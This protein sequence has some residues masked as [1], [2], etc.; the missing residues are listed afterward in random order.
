MGYPY[1]S[2]IILDDA[3]YIQY[4][5]E[6]GTST[7]AQRDAAYTIAEMLA[8]S[9]LGT[10]L[11]PTAVTGTYS[12]PTKLGEAIVLD[13]G[14]VQ[15]VEGVWVYS[16]S[17]YTSCEVSVSEG[18]VFMISDTYGYLYVKQIQPSCGGA[19]PP[20]QAKIAYTAGLPTGSAT[21][22]T[23]LLALTMLADAEI[24]EITDPGALEGG[25]GDPGVQQWGD[26]SYQER[27]VALAITTFGASPRANKAARLL[28]TFKH[29]RALRFH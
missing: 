24:K 19:Y 17:T 3:I 26:L 12:W 25:G 7:Q 21:L 1:S 5:G 20:Y 14:H 28:D 4:G 16:P 6:T 2:P 9:Y 15:S 22:P 8:S 27:R 10:Y 23:M 13:H 29:K 11:L 18:C